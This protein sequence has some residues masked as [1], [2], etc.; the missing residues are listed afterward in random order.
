ME[1]NTSSA[2]QGPSRSRKPWP[3][4]VSLCVALVVPIGLVLWGARCVVA[5]ASTDALS[6]RTS[7][8]AALLT[9]KAAR[10]STPLT[11]LDVWGA[12]MD[13]FESDRQEALRAQDSKTLAAQAAALQ[14]K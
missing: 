14:G 5:P 1:T 3:R 9:D 12:D 7:C 4:E 2:L 11:M 6:S 10:S 13:C 8:A